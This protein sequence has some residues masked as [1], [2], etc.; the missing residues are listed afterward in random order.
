MVSDANTG[1]TRYRVDHADGWFRIRDM[2]TGILI[3][4]MFPEEEE[5]LAF[6]ERLN[7]SKPGL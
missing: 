1:K 3:D 6:T 4:I 2:Q 5:A 7:D